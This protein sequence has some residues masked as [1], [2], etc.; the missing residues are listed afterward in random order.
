MQ[1]WLFVV[2]LLPLT[3]A[4]ILLLLAGRLSPIVVS[5]VGVGSMGLAALLTLFIGIE[6]FVS[7]AVAY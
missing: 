7:N 2:P 3:S 5:L 1:D 4:I 6:F